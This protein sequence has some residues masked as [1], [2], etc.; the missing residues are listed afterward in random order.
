MAKIPKRQKPARWK[1]KTPKGRKDGTDHWVYLW[2]NKDNPDLGYVGMSSQDPRKYRASSQNPDF[3]RDLNGGRLV[4][5]IIVSGISGMRAAI[6]EY[7]IYNKMISPPNGSIKEF[8]NSS[9]ARP[10][11]VK[12][13]SINAALVKTCVLICKQNGKQ[14]WKRKKGRIVFY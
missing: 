1:L 12:E 3:W 8:Y 7:A 14:G 4:R 6:L 9:C 2:R 10:T 11:F 5:E 13:D